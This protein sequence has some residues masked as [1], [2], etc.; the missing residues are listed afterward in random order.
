MKIAATKSG[1]AFD[2]FNYI[3]LAIF[4][5]LMLLPLLYVL[6]G[7]LT[8]DAELSLKK[9]VLIPMEP[10]LDSYRYILKS[11]IILQSLM[12]SIWITVV[13]TAINIFSTAVMAYPLSRRTLRGR[14]VVMRLVIFTM[15]FSG[16]MIPSYL[17]VK[18]LGM[19]NSYWSLW[20][21]GAIAAFNL[22]LMK[23][24]FQELPDGIEEAAKIDGCNDMQILFRMALPLSMPSIAALTLFYAVSNW[25]S[26]FN[27]LMYIQDSNKW[28]I[29]VWLQQIVILSQAGYDPNNSTTEF[30]KPPETVK[31]AVISVATLPILCIYPF[32]Q[33]Y[34]AKGVLL[35]SV[36]G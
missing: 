29:Q 26:F 21:P 10:T 19:L 7:S 34:F 23:N 17:L 36:K 11:G 35:G 25:N 16:G 27:A 12:Y 6:S 3:F 13:G 33:K 9:V 28:P 1:K 2:I 15:L 8:S 22:I 24:F 31:L 5:L 32:L 20:L 14:S 30:V 18:E 4:A